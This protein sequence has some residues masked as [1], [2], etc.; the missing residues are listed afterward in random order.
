MK[1]RNFLSLL[2][3]FAA[4]SCGTSSSS[5]KGQSFDLET[6]KWQ[7]QELNGRAI[8]SKDSSYTIEFASDGRIA[9]K[10]SCNVIVGNYKQDLSGKVDKLTLTPMGLTRS[11][12]PDMRVESEFVA[13]LESVTSYDVVDGVLTLYSDEE[14]VVRLRM[15]E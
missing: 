4:V 9:A 13:A 2:L 15:I 3:L 1:K 14:K 5:T 7:T 8:E 10:G 6:T 11:A 12:C